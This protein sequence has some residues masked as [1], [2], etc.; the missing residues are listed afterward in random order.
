MSSIMYLSK[1][2]PG[3]HHQLIRLRPTSRA[4]RAVT[5]ALAPRIRREMEAIVRKYKP[6][7]LKAKAKAKAEAKAKAK[8]RRK[9]G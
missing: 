7:V 2:R 1:R 5:K 4:V 3:E 8:A 6:I 9:R